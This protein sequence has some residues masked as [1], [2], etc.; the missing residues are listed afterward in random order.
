MALCRTPSSCRAA[1]ARYSGDRAMLGAGLAH[2]SAAAPAQE[3]RR[4]QCCQGTKSSNT[5]QASFIRIHPKLQTVCLELHS[6]NEVAI[7]N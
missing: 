3:R 7:Y 2:G 1:G 5:T 6:S 4:D